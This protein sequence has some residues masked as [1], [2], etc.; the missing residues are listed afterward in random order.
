MSW[1][2]MVPVEVYPLGFFAGAVIVFA[3]YRLYK[4]ANH[5]EAMLTKK[6]RERF[7]WKGV[8]DSPNDDNKQ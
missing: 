2:K 1:K 6:S 8:E 3:G 5:Q 4:L 7:A